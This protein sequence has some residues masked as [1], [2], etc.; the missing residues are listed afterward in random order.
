MTFND[1]KYNV[2]RKEEQYMSFIVTFAQINL[3]FKLYLP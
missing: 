3:Y 1:T 2:S